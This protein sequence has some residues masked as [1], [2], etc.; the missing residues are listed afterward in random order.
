MPAMAN[1]SNGYLWIQKSTLYRIQKNI[2]C[3][4]NKNQIL[5]SLKTSNCE[6]FGFETVESKYC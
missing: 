4:Q 5:K 2:C 6:G 3:D 1:N